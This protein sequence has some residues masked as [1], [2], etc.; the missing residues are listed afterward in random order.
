MSI[1]KLWVSSPENIR[2][3]LEAYRKPDLLKLQEIAAQ[4]GTTFHN[5]SHVIR[6]HM[7]EAERRALAALRYSDSKHGSKNPMWGKTGEQHHNWIGECEDGYGYLT[8]LHEGKRHFVHRIVM[9]QALG[10]K[11]LLP[12]TWAVHHID[13]D[14]KNNKIDNLALVTH[15]GHKAIHFMQVKDSLSLQLK[16]STLAEIFRSTTSR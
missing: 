7:P 9:A 1:S 6:K 8:C 10:L 16:R 11:S 15:A 14:T 4:L 2:S 12:E 5:V 3:A 13:G